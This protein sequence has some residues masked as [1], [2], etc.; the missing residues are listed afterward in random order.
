ML[1]AKAGE[2]K[3]YRYFET[4]FG[5]LMTVWKDFASRPQTGLSLPSSDNTRQ[6]ECSTGFLLHCPNVQSY[7]AGLGSKPHFIT[8]QL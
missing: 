7:P 3:A 2:G 1:G 6:P 8:Y 5:E 4:N